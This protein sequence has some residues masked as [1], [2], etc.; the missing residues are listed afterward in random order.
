[1]QKRT[2]AAEAFESLNQQRAEEGRHVQLARIG[3]Q[4][5]DE[6]AS[7]EEN[8]RAEAKGE[9]GTAGQPCG[10]VARSNLPELCSIEGHK[11][12]EGSALSQQGAFVRG[13]EL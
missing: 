10:W 7:L 12:I 3:A 1:M 5:M 4:R 11:S 8:T 6:A 9:L 2:S 13:L